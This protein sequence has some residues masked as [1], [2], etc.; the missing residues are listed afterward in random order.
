MSQTQVLTRDQCN[1][2][3][4]FLPAFKIAR[5][6]SVEEQDTF[7]ENVDSQW[8]TTWPECAVHFPDIQ[9]DRALS[10]LQQTVVNLAVQHRR[11]VR[12]LCPFMYVVVFSLSSTADKMVHSHEQLVPRD[13]LETFNVEGLFSCQEAKEV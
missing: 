9:D 13:T 3:K 5:S 11:R 6:G 1:M 12:H 7:W 10:S 8:F 4:M 2:L